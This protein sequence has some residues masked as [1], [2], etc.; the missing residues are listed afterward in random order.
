MLPVRQRRSRDHGCRLTAACQVAPAG[1]REVVHPVAYLRHFY[2]E[3]HGAD[4]GGLPPGLEF[5]RFTFE[6][7]QRFGGF[8][9]RPEKLAQKVGHDRVVVARDN[10]GLRRATAADNVP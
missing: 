7:D 10:G 8:A 6:C 3:L 4:G 1:T 9:W 2:V 5:H